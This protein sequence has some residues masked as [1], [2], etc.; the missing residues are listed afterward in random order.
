MTLIVVFHKMKQQIFIN[1]VTIILP[2]IKLDTKKD[3]GTY[4][5]AS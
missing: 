5:A 3:L 1:I 4:Q 2:Y